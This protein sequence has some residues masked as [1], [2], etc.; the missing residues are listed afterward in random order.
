MSIDNHCRHRGSDANDAPLLLEL[1]AGAGDGD[2]VIGGEQ[3]DQSEG[4]PPDGL[5]DAEAVE[6]WPGA[7]C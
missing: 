4:Q 6:P 5:G 1:D 7:R 3:R 2:V